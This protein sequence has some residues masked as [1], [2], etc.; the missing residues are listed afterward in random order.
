MMKHCETKSCLCRHAFTFQ[1]V[2]LNLLLLFCS[3]G[4][5]FAKAADYSRESIE[6]CDLWITHANETNLPRVLLIGDSIA[7][8][9]GPEVE[10]L[11]AGKAYVN[12]LATSAF[13]S[14]PMLLEQIKLV[15]EHYSF[16]VIQFNNG[17]HGWQHS[18]A[19]YRAAFPKFFEAIQKHSRG[20][21][22]VWADTTPLKGSTAS[23]ADPASA[24]KAVDNGK[25][26][27]KADLT[28]VSDER[29]AARNAIAHAFAAK[30]KIPVVDLHTPM[31]GHPEFHTDNVHFNP[32]GIGIQAELV[33]K[34]VS[35]LLQE[36]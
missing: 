2:W 22:L 10:N 7:R 21:K 9:Y 26:I 36:K 32:A 18:E 15:L 28:T 30:H 35:A 31:L 34:Q 12:R 14:D 25:L 24:N 13:I 27:L 16:D 5:L 29:I 3:T 33:A 23:N 11:L 17:M 19:E 4:G 1:V 6:W 20:A 8:A